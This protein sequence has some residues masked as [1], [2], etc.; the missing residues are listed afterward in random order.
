MKSAS[1]HIW[2]APAKAPE[3]RPGPSNPGW[4]RHDMAISLI[5]SALFPACLASGLVRRGRGT[6]GKPL[7][8][9]AYD[10]A[11]SSA[12]MVFQLPG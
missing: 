1:H 9:D 4:E 8:S 2:A 10:R 7:M 5:A 11:R 6:P 3:P 12:A